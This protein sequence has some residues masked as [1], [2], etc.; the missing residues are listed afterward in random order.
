MADPQAGGIQPFSVPGKWWIWL[1]DPDSH[2]SPLS[3]HWNESHPFHFEQLT[4]PQKKLM[5]EK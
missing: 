1:A 3:E 2:R 5:S 4:L